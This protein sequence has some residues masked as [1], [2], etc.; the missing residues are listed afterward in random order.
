M[1]HALDS[2]METDEIKYFSVQSEFDTWWIANFQVPT[3][4][5]DVLKWV[6]SQTEIPKIIES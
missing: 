2:S 5:H 4:N 1:N 6:F 3:E